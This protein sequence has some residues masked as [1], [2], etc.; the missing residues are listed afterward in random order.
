MSNPGPNKSRI[1]VEAVDGNGN[2]VY[3]EVLELGHTHKRPVK[4]VTAPET[5]FYVTP[6]GITLLAT[7]Y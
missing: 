1:P 6:D 5:D 4:D 2:K 7:G 3:G